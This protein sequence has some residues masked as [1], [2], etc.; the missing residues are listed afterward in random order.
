[1]LFS[2]LPLLLLHVEWVGDYFAP[3]QLPCKT[4]GKH[5]AQRLS[6][7]KLLLPWKSIF[8]TNCCNQWREQC[9]HRMKKN[10]KMFL[11]NCQKSQNYPRKSSR[12]DLPAHCRFSGFWHHIKSYFPGETPRWE[13]ICRG[14]VSLIAHH[15][16][17]LISPSSS[18]P[19]DPFPSF[20]LLLMPSP[21]E[22]SHPIIETLLCLGY[23][24]R[25]WLWTLFLPLP[26]P[27]LPFPRHEPWYLNQFWQE[28]WLPSQPLLSGLA[29]HHPDLINSVRC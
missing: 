15:S 26:Q 24:C 25:L 10:S 22:R 12:R 3:S 18:R 19:P 13:P 16:L 17:F 8:R 23:C 6:T 29:A 27:S 28:K 2:C 11:P 21:S 9:E 1:M 4:G 20:P 5:A 7:A 14:A